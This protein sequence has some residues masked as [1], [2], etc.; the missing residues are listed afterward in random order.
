ME[1]KIL[2]QLNLVFKERFQA[3]LQSLANSVPKYSSSQML[4]SKAKE[5]DFHA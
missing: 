5:N 4:I 2:K 1:D 3:G